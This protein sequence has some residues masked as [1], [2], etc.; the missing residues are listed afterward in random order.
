MA[1]DARI[2]VGTSASIKKV[3]ELNVKSGT[4]EKCTFY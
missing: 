3:I 4:D 2:G 1:A